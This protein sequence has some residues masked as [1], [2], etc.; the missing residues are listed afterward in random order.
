VSVR[1]PKVAT[2]PKSASASIMASEVPA[3]SDGRAIGS[4]TWRNACQ[5]ERPSVRA[6]SSVAAPC[7]R[8]AV[9]ASR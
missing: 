2:V 6:V 5:R 8:N 7:S 4:D 3:T 9:R 1:Y